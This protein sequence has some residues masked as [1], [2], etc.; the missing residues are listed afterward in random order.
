MPLGTCNRTSSCCF[1]ERSKM[2]AAKSP[3]KAKLS[4]SKGERKGEPLRELAMINNAINRFPAQASTFERS[5]QTLSVRTTL[6]RFAYSKPEHALSSNETE[7]KQIRTLQVLQ[8]SPK[9]KFSASSTASTIRGNASPFLM[10]A[11]GCG[12]KSP[13]RDTHPTPTSARKNVSSLTYLT[14]IFCLTTRSLHFCL[15][16]AHL[17]SNKRQILDPDAVS[18]SESNAS[19]SGAFDFE[20]ETAVRVHHPHCI[21]KSSMEDSGAHEVDQL[22]LTI[23]HSLDDL[24]QML[25]LRDPPQDLKSK[26]QATKE[27][28]TFRRSPL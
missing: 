8:S 17:L 9:R 18:L 22:I 13:R 14:R 11:A 2:K 16:F 20:N 7:S 19:N 26:Y 4:L 28:K 27:V 1:T 23:D 25:D 24:A 5:R 10:E 12:V 15:H 21:S 6:E 3:G